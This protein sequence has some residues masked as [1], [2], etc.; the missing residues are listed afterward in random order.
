LWESY[1]NGWPNNDEPNDPA[2]NQ[3]VLQFLQ[4]YCNPYVP[5][6]T[7]GIN[8]DL[9]NNG[10]SDKA[11]FYIFTSVLYGTAKT[12]SN[13]KYPNRYGAGGEVLA[14]ITTILGAQPEEVVVPYISLNTDDQAQSITLGPTSRGFVLFQYDPDSNGKGQAAWR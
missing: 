9:F 13:L 8:A 2:F 4:G 11:T 14:T 1:P 6:N 12:L 3:H 7:P 10:R 5:P